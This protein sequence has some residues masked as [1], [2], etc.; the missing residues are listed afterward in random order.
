MNDFLFQ[1]NTF[2]WGMLKC[3][4]PKGQ[5]ISK[6]FFE[7]VYFLQKMNENNSHTSKNEF[8][9]SFF[10]GNRWPHKPFQINPPLTHYFYLVCTKIICSS[11]QTYYK[12]I[13]F[14]LKWLLQSAPSV[15]D[16]HV[17]EGSL[18]F[19]FHDN[20]E[21]TDQFKVHKLHNEFMKSSFLPK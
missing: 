8:I 3:L 18:F 15:I 2:F 20:L 10:V 17:H 14:V 21:A 19:C 7:V 1:W 9:R 12:T 6:I 4:F 16:K 11:D 13:F 5:L